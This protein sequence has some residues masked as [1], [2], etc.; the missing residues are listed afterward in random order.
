MAKK[1]VPQI[2]IWA[3]DSTIEAFSNVLDLKTM[4]DDDTKW[5]MVEFAMDSF[6]GVRDGWD[7]EDTKFAMEIV[8]DKIAMAYANESV[9]S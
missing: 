1:D 5:R 4:V 6:L 7:A 2:A 8:K 9:V 3:A